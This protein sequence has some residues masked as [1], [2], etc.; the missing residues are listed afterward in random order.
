MAP[1]DSVAAEEPGQFAVHYVIG[2]VITILLN[3]AG[4][5]EHM[6]VVGQTRGIHL[7]PLS[8]GRIV[9]DSTAVPD[10]AA[11]GPGAGG[12]GIDTTGTVPDTTIVDPDTSWVVTS[13]SW[14]RLSSDPPWRRGQVQLERLPKGSTG[15]GLGG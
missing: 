14:V 15:G 8:Q 10:T 11:I 2:D 12:L 7:E 13:D 3:E 6:E 4:E 1:S 5:A 9:V